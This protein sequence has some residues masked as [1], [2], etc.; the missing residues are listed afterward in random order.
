[1][2]GEL[3]RQWSGNRGEARLIKMWLS[4]DVVSEKRKLVVVTLGTCWMGE[5]VRACW[6]PA[7]VPYLNFGRAGSV[8]YSCRLS[9]T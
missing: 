6:L 5:C 2:L 7:A 4:N 9:T 1:M 3:G 8:S